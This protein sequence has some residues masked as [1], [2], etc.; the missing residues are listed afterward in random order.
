MLSGIC[1]QRPGGLGKMLTPHA[2]TI[3]KLPAAP[4]QEKSG[5]RWRNSS[6]VGTYC[7]GERGAPNIPCPSADAS[8]LGSSSR[9]QLV[10]QEPSAAMHWAS[11]GRVQEGGERVLR[12]LQPF[13]VAKAT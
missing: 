13:R 6:P 2:A 10:M 3:I 12:R 8:T 5:D 1:W 7:A 4:V 9:P 11:R